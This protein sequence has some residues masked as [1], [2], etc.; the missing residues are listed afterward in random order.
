MQRNEIISKL[1]FTDRSS[2]RK[3]MSFKSQ[4]HTREQRILTIERR[5]QLFN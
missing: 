5:A 2:K 4:I 1:P 3:I